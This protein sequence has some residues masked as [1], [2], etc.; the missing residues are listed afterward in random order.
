VLAVLAA[1]V[2]Q[3][4][5][6]R[7]VLAASAARVAL[8]APALAAALRECREHREHRA[9]AVLPLVAAAAAT[10]AVEEPAVQQLVGV[11]ETGLPQMALETIFL[12]TI[13]RPLRPPRLA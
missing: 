12:L 5:L 9:S 10:V 6:L 7:Q 2:D 4:S 11:A 3:G 13:R 8:A 1:L